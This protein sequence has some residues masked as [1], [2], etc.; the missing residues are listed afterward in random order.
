M[1]R[2]VVAVVG[3][4]V[5]AFELGVLSEVFGLDRTADGLP[6]YSFAV[7]AVEPDLI[8][9][10]SGYA[11]KV[12]HDLTRLRSADL[13]A[14]PSWTTREVAPPADLV[15]ALHTAVDRGARVMSVC[16]GAFLLAAAG[17]LDG[18]RAAT[19]WCYAP[20]LAA[21]FPQ[22]EVDP[23]VL[24]VDAGSVITSAGTAAAIDACLHLVRSEH[25][26]T[27]ANALSRRMV[28]A[29]HRSGGQAQFIESA[30]PSSATGG[31]GEL[32][33]W[34]RSHLVEPLTVPQLA[35]RAV[36][37]PRTFARRFAAATGTTRTSGCSTNDC[38]RPSTCWRSPTSPSTRSP[39]ARASAARTTC[40]TTSRCVV[41]PARRPTAAPSVP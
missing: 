15:A 8:P 18:H 13:I 10:T 21:R 36:M 31:M 27:I 9:T 24:Y 3:D 26:A 7:A 12:E 23:D 1:P 25:G 16:S 4:T 17:L 6:A 34:M 30:V 2:D 37:S 33:G 32:L 20:A 41:V 14:V 22:I 19:H 40:G 38:R 28:V 5:A 39:A 35:A 11:V 29:P